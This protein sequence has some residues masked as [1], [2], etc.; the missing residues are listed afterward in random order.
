MFNFG[1]DSKDIALLALVGL[2]LYAQTNELDLANNTTILL[3][4][5]L[6]FMEHEEIQNLRREVYCV[7]RH[8]GT[9]YC[10]CGYNHYNRC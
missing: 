4:A 3:I 2:G 10:R 7:E 8:T 9:S 5:Y 1:R 6:L